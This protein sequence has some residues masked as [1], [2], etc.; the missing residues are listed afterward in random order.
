MCKVC[1]GGVCHVVLRKECRLVLHMFRATLPVFETYLDSLD[2]IKGRL[3][4]NNV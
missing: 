3:Q 4:M 1:L 2:H